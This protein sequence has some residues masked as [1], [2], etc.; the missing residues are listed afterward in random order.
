MNKAVTD[1]IVF[2]PTPF[3]AGLGVWSTTTGRPGTPTY[4][5]AGGGVFVPADQDFSGCM[6][7]VKS[8]A[9][10]AVRYMGQTPV[11]PGCY[12]QVT[13]RV[14]AVAGALPSVRIA[15]NPYS[16]GN[17]ALSGTTNFG[18]SRQLTA[19]GEV[20]EI[21]AIFG[22]GAR[23]GVNMVWPTA[24]YA[25]IGLDLTGPNGGVV[26]IDDIRIE[27]VSSYYLSDAIGIVDV[28][29]YGALGNGTTNDA[30]AF[31]RAD[32]AA[33]GREVL[34]SAGTY[35]L[36]SDVTFQSQVRFVGTVVMTGTE[37][38]IL[39][40]NFDYQTY[41]DAFGDEEQAFRKAFQ[42]LLNFS[43]HD[44][45]DLG[46][47]R[48]GLTGPVDMQATDP[49]KTSF[50]IRRLI[51]N[52]QF[53]ALDSP[54][55][56]PSVATSTASYAAGS[57][58]LTNVANVAAIQV[59]SL[60]TGNGVGREIYVQAVNVAQNRVTLSHPLYGAAGSQSY[61]FTRFKYMLDFSG[62]FNLA[63]FTL[64][65][66]EFQ[67]NGRASCLMLSQNGFSNQIR[68]CYFTRP[69]HR[70]ITSTGNGCQGLQI[71]RCTFLSNE[72][73]LNAQNRVTIGMNLN[74]NDVRLTDCIVVKFRHWAVIA[75]AGTHIVGNHWYQGDEG[76]NGI[77]LGGIVFTM[78]NIGTTITG[79]YIDNN[80]IEWTNEHDANPN[81]VGAAFTFG[82]LT[83]TS[84]FCIVSDMAPGFNWLVIK[85][86]GTGHSIAGLTVSHNVFRTLNG[87]ITRIERVDTTF[88]N[89]NYGLTRNVSFIGNVFN[90]VTEPVFN[91][92]TVTHTQSTSDRIWIVD[93][94]TALPFKGRLRTVELVVS[95]DRPRIS[96]TQT[97]YAQPYV[98]E[99][100]GP[101]SDQF[102][103]IWDVPVTGRIRA[104]VRMDN[105]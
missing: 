52:G 45:L 35:R 86:Y 8:S 21:T 49:S 83:L 75:G 82:G 92:L 74:A 28:R 58:T 73:P 65:D 31:E 100:Y 5:G 78:P 96:G 44:G 93:P 41:L 10:Q 85:P 64:A 94:G 4:A 39:Q 61:T 40:R 91:P 36:A 11:Q 48:I 54:A 24:A 23:G 16:S 15:G 59:G 88:A 105:P 12:L 30:A 63:I 38:L 76:P 27:D 2:D 17:V 20:V 81:L 72:Q 32:A 77:R 53:E 22:T 46:G 68:D 79:N 84:N 19:Y 26:R 43:D 33:N 87:T 102:R 95:V 42:A 51:R 6:E 50:A 37:R 71:D 97:S 14:K 1:G 89:L 101:Q 56:T 9:T 60:V 104:V 62:F 90:G 67:G 99:E 3:S 98:D 29:D 70:G 18:P 34:V 47:R 103:L 13:V 80:F 7:I 55:W 25:H 66:I 57:Q 69:S